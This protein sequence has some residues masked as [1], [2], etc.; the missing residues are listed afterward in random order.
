MTAPPETPPA[1][2]HQLRQ[3]FGF[4]SNYVNLNHGWPPPVRV[5]PSHAF[6]PDLCV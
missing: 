5:L 6:W 4:E 2:G 1:F 3:Y